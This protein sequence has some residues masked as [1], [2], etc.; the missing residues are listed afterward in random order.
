MAGTMLNAAKEA[1]R[2]N[3]EWWAQQNPKPP[4]QDCGKPRFDRGILICQSCWDERARAEARRLEVERLAGALL[5]GVEHRA[6]PG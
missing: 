3:R 6:V 4:C 5:D 2:R 1:D